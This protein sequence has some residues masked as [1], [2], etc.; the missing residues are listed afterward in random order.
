MKILIFLISF[1]LILFGIMNI[2]DDNVDYK[3]NGL[4]EILIGIVL[5]I[6]GFLI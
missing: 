3:K 6:G 1:I 4:K 5:V 2:I